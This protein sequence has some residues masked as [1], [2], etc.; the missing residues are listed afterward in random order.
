MP[1]KVVHGARA[2]V[3]IMDPTTGVSTIVGIFNNFSYGVTYDVQPAFILGRFSAA[4]L[5]Y[6]AMEPVQGTATGWRVVNH[7][8]FVEP[9]LPQLQ[10]LLSNPYIE[11]QVVDR[12][13]L[14]T[15]AQ[16]H[17]VRASGFSTTIAAR[18]LQEITMTYV[19]LLFDDESTTNAETQSPAG[20]GELP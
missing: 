12:Q 14:A 9:K 5:G 18:Q 4:E 10:Q 11:I 1:P 6:T 17:S 3:S 20:T 2:L 7:G 15:I 8:P 19:G 16:I 13:T